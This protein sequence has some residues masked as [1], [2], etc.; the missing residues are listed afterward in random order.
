[1]E[2]MKLEPMQLGNAAFNLNSGGFV[3]KGKIVMTEE[4]FPDLNDAFG[5]DEPKKKAGKK[6]AKKKGKVAVAPK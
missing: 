3:P 1:M 6:A 4:Y 2:P 5:D